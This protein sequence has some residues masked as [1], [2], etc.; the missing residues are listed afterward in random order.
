MPTQTSTPSRIVKAVLDD[1]GEDAVRLSNAP[2][3]ASQRPSVPLRLWQ[4]LVKA[5]VEAAQGSAACR[6]DAA[7]RHACDACDVA[8]AIAGLEVE[9]VDEC[10]W[11]VREGINGEPNVSSRLHRDYGRFRRGARTRL[12]RADRVNRTLNALA[13]LQCKAFAAGSCGPRR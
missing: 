7:D 9:S 3:K 4:Q 8:V 6:A 10:A 1:L 2:V 13:T 12:A 5:G 11:A